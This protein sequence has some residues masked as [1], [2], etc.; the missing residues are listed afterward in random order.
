MKR[1]LTM[2]KQLPFI[3]PTLLLAASSVNAAIF[4]KN[5]WDVV[6]Y[7]GVDAQ[8]RFM[9]LKKDFGGNLAAKTYPQGNVFVGLRFC[10]YWGVEAGYESTTKR[11]RTATILGND[12]AFGEPVD[13]DLPNDI[14]KFETKTKI[15]GPN[16]NI[17]GFYPI[18]KEYCV[19]LIGS[20][21]LAYSKIKI[22]N[23]QT[24]GAGEELSIQNSELFRKTFKKSKVIAR[25]NL[26]IQKMINN[27][28]GIRV[29]VGWENTSRLNNI[30]VVNF[31]SDLVAKARD[32]V[33]V[34]FG[35]FYSFN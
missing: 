18:S 23:V 31:S 14:N 25:A 16:I 17:I 11:N 33:N 4:E 9:G 1:N 30:K 3:L 34:G 6:P 21:G 13:P 7:V 28:F 20:V 32:S 35:I 26:G 15:Y 19:D 27:Q 24:I 29:M 5:D 22:E 8:A 12:N 10:D 2:I